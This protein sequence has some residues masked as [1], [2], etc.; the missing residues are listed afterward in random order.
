LNALAIIGITGLGK[1]AYPPEARPQW[2]RFPINI[3]SNDSTLPHRGTVGLFA[4]ELRFGPPYS[5]E[6]NKDGC[7]CIPENTKTRRHRVRRGIRGPNADAIGMAPTKA[8]WVC[9]DSPLERK[10]F[11]PSVLLGFLL[12]GSRLA[13]TAHGRNL[14]AKT[15]GGAQDRVL[16]AKI[17]FAVRV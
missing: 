2:Q 1:T 16:A 12:S 8:E 13:P 3:K 10:G 9:M 17:F 6:A 14:V 15:T 4:A 5:P 11:E 7:T